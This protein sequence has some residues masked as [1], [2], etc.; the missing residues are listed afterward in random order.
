MAGIIL[1]HVTKIYNGGGRAVD[2]LNL[3]IRDGEFIVLVGPSGCGKTTALRMVA[4]LE[5]IT[6]GT[7]A[8]G[9]R[10]VNEI[11][12]GDRDIAMVFQNYALYPHMSVFEN[13]AFP[14]RAKKV[15]KTEVSE[16]VNKVAA[17]LA[18]TDYLSRK[19]RTLSGGQRQRVAMGR[20]LV[21]EPHA[22]LMDEPLS[23]LDAKLRMQMRAEISAL[24]MGLG[25]TTIYVT[26]DQVEAMTM[27]TKIAVMRFGV[28]QQYGTPQE[29]YTDPANIFVA[30]FIG[31]PGMNFMMVG[32]QR[33]GDR[34]QLALRN[35]TVALSDDVLREHPALASYADRKVVL[36]IRPEHLSL[37]GSAGP[38][39]K[40]RVS[41][42]EL[43][44]GEK[45]IYVV[46]DAES[47]S[48]DEVLNLD[49]TDP[50]TAKNSEQDQGDC[51][52]NL[53]VR[54]DSSQPVSA[55]D[56][57]TLSMR[58]GCLHFFERSGGKSIAV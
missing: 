3:D 43:L 52:V 29:V 17:Q 36:G 58:P 56:T 33:D 41:R 40:A 15:S 13:I 39:F 31:S 19:P 44:G 5:E 28:L 10:I 9:D 18:L 22:F 46:T 42:V 45:L 20:A 16:R 35:Q 12:P 4:G 55:G 49:G 11:D 2:D 37:S 48:V 32:V 54:A 26:H 21:R 7:I 23:N 53:I 14:L 50:A 8:I 47:V 1:E 57:V 34:Y 38:F 6:S 27:G 30:G 24:Q 51:G 25:I